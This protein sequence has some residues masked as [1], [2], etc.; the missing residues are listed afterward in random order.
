MT[1]YLLNIVHALLF[2]ATSFRSLENIM[3][4]KRFSLRK[5]KQIILIVLLWTSYST[6]CNGEAKAKVG[7]SR[8]WI[9]YLRVSRHFFV[10]I[11][12]YA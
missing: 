12:T 6:Y 8:K 10:S 11:F 7:W 2:H 5:L 9:F 3:H 4:C 1:C